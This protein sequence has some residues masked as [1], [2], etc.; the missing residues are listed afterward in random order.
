MCPKQVRIT[1]SL[2]LLAC[3]LL[4]QSPSPSYDCC[5]PKLNSGGEKHQSFPTQAGYMGEP[6]SVEDSGSSDGS[7]QILFPEP[8]PGLLSNTKRNR[9]G[10]V[11]PLII[12][13]LCHC[14]QLSSPCSLAIVGQEWLWSSPCLPVIW[15]QWKKQGVE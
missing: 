9:A 3:L 10:R 13:N 1:S 12:K 4:S 11:N 8:A 2:P 14:L 7:W 5:S 15:G 6:G